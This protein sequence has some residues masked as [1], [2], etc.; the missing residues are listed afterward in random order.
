MPKSAVPQP[1]VGIVAYGTVLPQDCLLATEI[2]TAQGVL[3]VPGLGVEQKTVAARDEDAATLSV[4]AA[5]QALSRGAD[6]MLKSKIGALWIGSESHPYAVKPTGTMVAAALGLPK[7]M[8]LADLQFACKAGTQ[9]LAQAVA[10]VKSGFASAAMAI[11]ADTAQSRPGDILEYTA[12]AGGAAYVIGSEQV[13]CR[14]IGTASYATDTP[15]FWRRAGQPY[16]EHAGRFTAEPAYFAHIE[17][18]VTQLL[19]KLEMTI[20]DFDHCVFHTPNGNFPVT[21]ARQLGATKEQLRWSLP[22]SK[23]GNTYAAATL[24]AFAHVLDHAEANEKI[25]VASY[26][27]G[28]GSD[29]FVWETTDLLPKLRQNWTD[30]LEERIAR[31][32]TIS[33]TEYSQRRGHA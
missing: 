21:I 18:S 20:S 12:A 9:G 23:I 19:D 11:G 28:A 33:Y 6:M 5:D 14:F 13:V 10:S 24:L 26:G 8:A 27:S 7:R 17:K 30:L 25:L 1:D 2:A 31:L 3:Q 16:P 4:A 32:Q 29:A 15:D 22:V